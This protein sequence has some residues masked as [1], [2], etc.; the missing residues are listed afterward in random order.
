MLNRF[1]QFVFDP[2]PLD[3]LSLNWPRLQSAQAEVTHLLGEHAQ[4]SQAVAEL[5]AGRGAA[6]DRDLDDAATAIRAGS[7]APSPKVL[8]ALE[9][10]IEGAIRTRDAVGRAVSNALED[11]EVF[12][13]KHAG[14]LEADAARS[15][16]ALRSKLAEKA[17]HTAALYRE[18]ESA[19]AS[20]KKLAPPAAP[21]A[22]TGPPGSGQAAR[23][24]VFASQFVAT[25]SQ[26][27]ASPDRGTVER[28]LSH[29]SGLA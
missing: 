16:E 23:S 8:P 1:G 26:R 29:L 21:P 5:E 7:G 22:E 19:A 13:R 17:K 27:S 10:K 9:R 20:V 11:L 2:I 18:A 4:A 15:L 6:K 12:K 3:A 14:A 25:T 28:V 24:T